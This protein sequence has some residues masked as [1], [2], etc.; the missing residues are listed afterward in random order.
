MYV[1]ETGELEFGINFFEIESSNGSK[2]LVEN[3]V[4]NY[5]KFH[6]TIL[7]KLYKRVREIF[8][9]IPTIDIRKCRRWSIEILVVDGDIYKGNTQ[10]N[11]M[12]YLQL[13]KSVNSSSFEWAA[14]IRF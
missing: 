6:I 3:E 14:Q 4:C 1:S 8:S 2:L 5:P 12:F 11:N 13:Q 7:K 10:L 9:K